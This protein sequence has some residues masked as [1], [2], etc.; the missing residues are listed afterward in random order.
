VGARAAPA[1]VLTTDAAVPHGQPAPP[2]RHGRRAAAVV[3]VV[4]AGLVAACSGGSSAADRGNTGR[5]DA[6]PTPVTAPAPTAGAPSTAPPT[7]TAPPPTD[8]A[9]AG[10]AYFPTLGN[11]GYDVARYD[12][13]L[14]ADPP[15][16]RID[17]QVV[18]AA[19]ATA[20]LES[21]HL[22][23][24]GMEVASVDVD[25]TAA[26]FVRDGEE[27]VVRPARTLR[28]G[29]RFTTTVRY[30]GTPVPMR[31]PGQITVG[32]QRA[33]ST[34][35]VAS[36]PNGAH[37]WLASN[38]HPGD[39]A[40]YGFRIDV[41]EGVTAVANG[42]LVSST[43]TG[44]RTSW[45][46]EAPEPVATYLVTVAIGSF[47]IVDAGEHA[48]VR[49][50][51]VFPTGL[52]SQLDAAFASTASMIDV[53]DDLFGPYPFA[54]YGALVIDA[55]LGYA[56]ETQTLSLFDR[57][58][59]LSS[60]SAAFQV[61]EL[62]HQWFGNSVTPRTWR[63][64]WL[65]EGFATYAEH[66]YRE[67]TEPAY[68][69]DAQMRRSAA[70]SW[71]PIGDP[72][73]GALFERPVYDRGALVLHAL[74]RTVGDDVFFAILRAWATERRHANGSTDEFV[75]LSSRV[76]GRDVGGLVR[77]WLDDDPMPALP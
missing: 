19:T 33:G 18:I 54:A 23:L 26:T 27:L 6:P 75:A 2:A 61:H 34:T 31:D 22:D 12:V 38:D 44:G 65:N 56:L 32:W 17:V 68:D 63:D 57:A 58:I 21:F 25:G 16:T 30:A 42:T 9:G 60:G 10:D 14:R 40:A 47:T 13:T 36:E 24:A 53:L 15:A 11:G 66:L 73:P 43:T 5:G 45:V 69:T 4:L 20:T 52:S 59:A 7:T 48:G 62:A 3:A 37:A 8:P 51:H 74:R 28:A 70:R 1:S 50:R 49:L 72:G 64:I 76:A 71:P 39:K 77:S 46:W 29:A 55:R 41:P 35:F 67:R